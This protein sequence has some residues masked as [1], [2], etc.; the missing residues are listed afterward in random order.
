MSWSATD[1]CISYKE[2]ISTYS[3]GKTLNLLETNSYE[4]VLWIKKARQDILIGTL[5]ES[6]IKLVEKLQCHK[7]KGLKISN[8]E[9]LN[10]VDGYV[11]LLIF[12]ICNC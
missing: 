8:F 4:Q 11:Q 1:L 9:T 5:L 10:P 7:E 2:L 3:R 12:K 6:I